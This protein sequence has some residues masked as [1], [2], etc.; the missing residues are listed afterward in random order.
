ME[1]KLTIT[2]VYTDIVTLTYSQ[3]SALLKKKCPTIDEDDIRVLWNKTR[4][5]EDFQTNH[6]PNHYD[7]EEFTPNDLRYNQKRWYSVAEESPLDELIDE[8]FED[9]KQYNEVEQWDNVYYEGV[10]GGFCGEHP[11]LQ[12]FKVATYYQTFGGGPEGGYLVMPDGDVYE[13]KRTWGEPFDLPK[14]LEGKKLLRKKTDG[15]WMC[16]LI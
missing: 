11:H 4:L 10:F 8:I 6:L 1:E 13:T 2:Q 9:L 15:N 14:K 5:D 16:R 7:M 12:D 3:F